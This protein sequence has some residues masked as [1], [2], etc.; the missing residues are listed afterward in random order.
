MIRRPPRSTR[1]D[2]L[3]PYTTLFRSRVGFTARDTAELRSASE[4]LEKPDHC[5]RY[6]KP[7]GHA[8]GRSKVAPSETGHGMPSP[9]EPGCWPSSI[10]EETVAAWRRD[11]IN[12]RIF[13]CRTSGVM[14]PTC[15]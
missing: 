8:D 1:T 11:S 13:A 4:R 15:L 14:A 2:T 5:D 6:R 9:A 10:S 3:F 7:T 12:G